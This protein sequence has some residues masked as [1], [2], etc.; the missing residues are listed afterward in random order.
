MLNKME[1]VVNGTVSFQN[2]DWQKN[3]RTFVHLRYKQY[4]HKLYDINRYSTIV[5][6][7]DDSS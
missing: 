1:E 5:T 4:I 6:V 2:T 3:G 7:I